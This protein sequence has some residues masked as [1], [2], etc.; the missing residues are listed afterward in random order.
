MVHVISATWE[1]AIRR[2]VVQGQTGQKVIM[3]PVLV[4]EP[5]VVVQ[6]QRPTNK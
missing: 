4:S 3:T 1:E 2:T 5:Y 6:L